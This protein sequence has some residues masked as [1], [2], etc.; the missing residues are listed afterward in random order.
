[1]ELGFDTVACASTGNLGNS[2]AAHAAE[3]GLRCYMLIPH[4]LETGKVLGTI[5]YAPHL[6]RIDG[7]YDDVNRLCSEIADH[8]DW[9]FVNVNIRPYYAEGSKSYGYEIPEQLG[10]RTRRTS[11][12]RWPAARC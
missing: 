10:W 2:T 8:Y 9:A 7:T 6:V 5:I 4:D 3:A 11:S 1:M 12:C